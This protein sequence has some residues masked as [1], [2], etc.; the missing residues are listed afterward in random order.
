M[1]HALNDRGQICSIGRRHHGGDAHELCMEFPFSGF[2]GKLGGKAPGTQPSVV[3]Q[4]TSMDDI[5][6]CRKEL[7]FKGELVIIHVESEEQRA[8]FFTKP[9]NNTTFRNHRDCL[10]NL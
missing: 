1:R 5:I 2:R 9:F 7:H 10:M 4:R 3:I 6:F 8:D